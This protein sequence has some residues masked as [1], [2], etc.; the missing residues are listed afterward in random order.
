MVHV[1]LNNCTFLSILMITHI[2]YINVLLFL[3][4]MILDVSLSVMD[5]N[6][7]S[8]PDDLFQVVFMAQA[9]PSSWR[10]LLVYSILLHNP[11]LAVLAACDQVATQLF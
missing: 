9:T 7:H 6:I 11:I 5:V 10:A 3:V 8:I 1:G 4:I 2:Y